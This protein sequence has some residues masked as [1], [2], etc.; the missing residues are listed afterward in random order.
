MKI[1]GP[2]QA[3]LFKAVAVTLVAG[4]V[5]WFGKKMFDK[6]AEN[7]AGVANIPERITKAV[8]EVIDAGVTAVKETAVEGGGAW[9]QGFEPT[10]SPTGGDLKK[11]FETPNY[12]TPYNSPLINESGMDFSQVSG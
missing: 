2:L 7:V 10:A 11:H 3:E 1:S 9:K 6:L 12:Q 8:G 5:I 4:G